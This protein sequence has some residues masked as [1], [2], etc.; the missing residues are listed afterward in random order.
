[1]LLGGPNNYLG[2]S[3]RVAHEKLKISKTDFD[4]FWNHTEHAMKFYKVEQGLIDE[5]KK[6]IYSTENDI[7]K[8]ESHN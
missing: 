8:P 4:N 5:V 3:M 7:V 1:M 2:K 6:V